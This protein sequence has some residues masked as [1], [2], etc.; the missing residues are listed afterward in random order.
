MAADRTNFVTA[1]A[2]RDMLDKVIA[3]NPEALV[4]ASTDTGFRYLV[5]DVLNDD[6]DS[7]GDARFEL[8]SYETGKKVAV[9]ETADLYYQN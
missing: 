2:L 8:R 7:D 3:K 1:V 9:V 5:L 4:M 6:L